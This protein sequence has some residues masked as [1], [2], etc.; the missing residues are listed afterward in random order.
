MQHRSE[1]RSRSLTAAIVACVL[2]VGALAATARTPVANA[3]YA[4]FCPASGSGSVL[5]EAYGRC[6]SAKFYTLTRVWAFTT[7]GDGV[8]HCAVGKEGSGGTGGNVIDPQCGTPMMQATNC[9][10]P[11]AGYATIVSRSPSAHYFWGDAAYGDSC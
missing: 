10:S 2:L 5:I 4:Y 6:A 1:R 7:N 8:E 3:G 11:R 9:Y